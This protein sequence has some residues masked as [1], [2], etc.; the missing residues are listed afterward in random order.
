MTSI[1][2]ITGEENPNLIYDDEEKMVGEFEIEIGTQMDGNVMKLPE[3]EEELVQI[4]K[5]NV[6]HNCNKMMGFCS[7]L[8]G[9]E[10]NKKISR[11]RN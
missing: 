9:E 2:E 3:T 5:A 7:K 10:F 8:L 6:E 1:D 4:I 11:K